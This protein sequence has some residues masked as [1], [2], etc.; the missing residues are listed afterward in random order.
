[1]EIDPRRDVIEAMIPFWNPKNNVFQFFDFEMTPTLKEITRLMGKGSSVWGADLCD[2]KPIIPKS[3]DAKK[4]LDL[5]KIN[6]IKKESLINGC[7]SVDFL[8]ERYGQK[9]GL[10]NYQNQLSNQG[11]VEA[12]KANGIPSWSHFWGSLFNPNGKAY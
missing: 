2:K 11:G 8:Y 5:F 10:K 3:V 9:D 1:M 6:Q 4:F 12:L 7:F